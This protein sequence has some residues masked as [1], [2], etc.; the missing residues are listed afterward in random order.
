LNRS[1]FRE[2]FVFFFVGEKPVPVIVA[3]QARKKTE[4][5]GSEI[6]RHESS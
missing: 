2:G 4:E 1:L 5:F 3:L 6:R